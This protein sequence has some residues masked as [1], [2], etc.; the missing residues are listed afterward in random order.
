MS[1]RWQQKWSLV[2]TP[3]AL[4]AAVGGPIQVNLN[5]SVV[6]TGDHEDFYTTKK[7]TTLLDAKK[8][9]TQKNHKKSIHSLKDCLLAARL[10]IGY[11]LAACHSEFN[12]AGL[13]TISAH[14]GV[15]DMRYTRIEFCQG[16]TVFECL[17][18][19]RPQFVRHLASQ[20]VNKTTWE[21]IASIFTTLANVLIV[22][23]WAMPFMS[24]LA[25][26]P[27]GNFWSK[28]GVSGRPKS[29]SPSM[30]PIGRWWRATWCGM[31][32]LREF[33]PKMAMKCSIRWVARLQ[34]GSKKGK[35]VTH[36]KIRSSNFHLRN[37]FT[38]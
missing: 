36:Q 37:F 9:Q 24:H 30:V 17:E 1:W 3:F 23:S 16:P 13:H 32:P 15:M 38:R 26:G 22:S 33:T 8:F 7:G 18:V 31:F 10:P 11:E 21:S 14:G 2:C 6:I 29:A 5:R 12:S 35:P 25:V 4:A 28:S 34:I 27:F 19:C 20:V